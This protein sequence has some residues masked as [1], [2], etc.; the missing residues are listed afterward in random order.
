M[1]GSLGENS[2]PEDFE[3]H[4]QDQNSDQDITMLRSSV[5]AEQVLIPA[6]LPLFSEKDITPQQFIG[7]FCTVSLLAEKYDS[8]YQS[9]LGSV[10]DIIQNSRFNIYVLDEAGNSALHHAARRGLYL[11]CDALIRMKSNVRKK[12]F[13]GKRPLDYVTKDSRMYRMMVSQE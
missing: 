7:M 5:I 1:P 3:L 10:I 8:C 11:L 2:G 13:F 4:I 12:N 6:C 9:L